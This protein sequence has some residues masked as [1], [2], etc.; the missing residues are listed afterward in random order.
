MQRA[1]APR[2]WVVAGHSHGADVA[3][4]VASA[5]PPGLGGVVLIAMA[6]PDDANLSTLR[7]PVTTVNGT[8]DGIADSADAWNARGKLPPATRWVWVPGGNHSNVGWYGFQPF[9]RWAR[10]E[11]DK[12]RDMMTGAVMAAL[13]RAASRPRTP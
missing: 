13:A 9:D 1:N 11:P 5:K 10:I 8:H 6:N 7:V 4:K 3:A 12:Q 2:S